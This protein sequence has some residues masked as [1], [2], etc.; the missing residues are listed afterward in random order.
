MCRVITCHG[1][2]GCIVSTWYSRNLPLDGHSTK[3]SEHG[4]S[5]ADSEIFK[6]KDREKNG[7]EKE[8]EIVKESRV[9]K[10]GAVQKE[11]L[12]FQSGGE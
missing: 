10:K 3:S 8:S 6:E 9:R 12:H 4:L 11:E 7:K 2:P 5:G 1:E